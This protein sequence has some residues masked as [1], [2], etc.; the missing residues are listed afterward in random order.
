MKTKLTLFLLLTISLVN[1][2]IPSFATKKSLGND[3]VARINAGFAARNNKL[4]IIGGYANCSPKDFSEYDPSTGVMNKLKNLGNGCANPIYAKCTFIVQNK[5]YIVQDAR[6]IVYD[7]ATNTWANPI[8]LPVPIFFNADSGFVI[9]DVIYVCSSYANWVCSYNTTNGQAAQNADFPGLSSRSNAFGFAINGKGYLGGGGNSS[10]PSVGTN[11]FYEYDPAM[12]TWTTKASLPIGFTAGVGA[13]VNGKGYAGTGNGLN[14]LTNSL[15]KSYYWYEYDPIANTWTS[16][17]N[18]MN[19]N[20]PLTL[21]NNGRSESSVATIGNDI[22]LF[23]G[24]AQ[25]YGYED[26]LHKYNTVTNTWSVVDLEIGRNRQDASGFFLN[27]KVYVG[28]GEDSE[29]LN[30]FWE[31]DTNIDDWIQKSNIPTAYA[32]RATTEVNG[33]GYC[34]GGYSNS[35]QNTGAD[36][37]AIYSDELL[38]YNSLTDVW[39]A[40]TPYPAGKR[41]GMIAMTY[42]GKLYAGQGT[43]FNGLQTNGFAEYNPITN[44]WS[45]KISV[46]F[47]G[48]FCSSFVIGNIGYV[49][50]FSPNLVGK[51]NFDTNSWTTEPHSMTTNTSA[52]GYPNQKAF[53]YNGVGYLADGYAGLSKYNPA[54]STWSKITNLPFTNQLQ[55]II[56]ANNGVYIGFGNPYAN[57]PLGLS[58]VNDWRFMKFDAAVSNKFGVYKTEN[59]IAD[60]SGN[61]LCTT[62]N[63]TANATS[64][65]Y[66]ING[67]LFSTIIAGTANV[68]PCLEVTSLNLTTPFRTATRDFGN[69]VVETGMFLNK[70]ITVINENNSNMM[71]GNGTLRL[72]YTTAELNKL[73]TDFN[74]LY[75]TTKTIADIKLVRYSHPSSPLDADPL[76]NTFANSH[77]IYNSS[78]VNY[79]VDKYYD[80]VTTPTAAVRGEIYAVLL[81]GQNLTNE[82]FSN[83]KISV[84]P[85]PATNILNISLEENTTIDRLT[86]TDLSGKKILEQVGNAATVNIESLANGMYV[87]QVFANG[88]KMVNKFIKN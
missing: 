3:M 2:Q 55:N 47:T 28:G 36:P 17:Q 38:E 8:Q 4:Y 37:N 66:D 31:Y 20:Q 32:K 15:Y 43:N 45:N 72:Y 10:T 70:S 83:N 7:F 71:S 42:N 46:P 76:N 12:D 58:A 16:K 78:I 41:L 63:L 53:T 85:N 59:N 24:N 68:G 30:D 82:V 69:G 79:G 56:P 51:Y 88:N 14:Q 80:I 1:A 13:S 57:H 5:L 61:V 11:S 48:G 75:G 6:V 62:G 52:S 18:F 29:F 34:I 19:S 39:T 54:T 26:S 65:V 86:I 67:D 25:F 49:V 84:Y 60:I 22:Y 87:L 64:S 74:T 23:G 50:S 77:L 33:K 27:G 40:K 35:V 44:T 81:A 73:V 9:N 21:K